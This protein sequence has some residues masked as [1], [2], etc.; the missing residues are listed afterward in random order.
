MEEIELNAEQLRFYQEIYE[1]SA[2]IEKGSEQGPKVAAI[3][4][5]HIFRS[6]DLSDEAI[7]KVS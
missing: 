2:E 6:A 1:Y 4:A 7:N 3:K 5:F